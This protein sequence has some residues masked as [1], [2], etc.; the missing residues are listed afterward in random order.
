MG[1]ARACHLSEKCNLSTATGT[2]EFGPVG[3]PL[4]PKALPVFLQREDYD[5]WL[6]G[7]AADAC[8]LAQAFPSQLMRVA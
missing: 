8:S 7:E 2:P 6:D 4:H 1:R 5:K 3:R